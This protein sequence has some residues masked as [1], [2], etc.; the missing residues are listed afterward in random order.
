MGL[1]FQRPRKKV[2]MGR[3]CHC[4]QGFLLCFRISQNTIIMSQGLNGAIID[5]TKIKLREDAPERVHVGTC[6]E[7]SQ[8]EAHEI[9]PGL[10]KALTEKDAFVCIINTDRRGSRGDGTHWRVLVLTRDEE[11]PRSKRQRTGKEV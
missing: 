4:C 5:S 8:I 2:G 1:A 6:A 9:S 11:E 10:K 3:S 7:L